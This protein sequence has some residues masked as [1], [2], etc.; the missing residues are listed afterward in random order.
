MNYDCTN[1]NPDELMCR[2]C[3]N[4]S[5]VKNINGML[6]KIPNRIHLRRDIADTSAALASF[7]YNKLK[8]VTTVVPSLKSNLRQLCVL[9]NG[10]IQ[11]KEFIK[12]NK[13]DMRQ[14]LRIDNGEPIYSKQLIQSE[15]YAT[16]FDTYDRYKI[17]SKY[18]E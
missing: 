7:Y 18:I 9:L 15:Y 2:V 13:E 16:E 1:C 3:R 17:Y 6:S 12:G 4:D 11:K 5:M 8:N 10:Y 14:L